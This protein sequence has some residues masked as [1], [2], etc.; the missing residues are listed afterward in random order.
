MELTGN[1]GQVPRVE[2]PLG[3]EAATSSAKV[4][5]SELKEYTFDR[6]KAMADKAAQRNA[7]YPV[8]PCNIY[9]SD[10]SICD[11]G[12][13]YDLLF[14]AV[15]EDLDIAKEFVDAVTGMDVPRDSIVVE[16]QRTFAQVRSEMIEGKSPMAKT[17]IDVIIRSKAGD[18]II[19]IQTY[20]QP[21]FA[22]RLRYYGASKD[23]SDSTKVGEEKYNLPNV[24]CVAFCSDVSM[25]SFLASE[26]CYHYCR[27]IN[28]FGEAI[29]D[30]R[31][32]I[33]I[34]FTRWDKLLSEGAPQAVADIAA[35]LAG[36]SSGTRYS[37]SIFDKANGLLTDTERSSIMGYVGTKFDDMRE[38]FLREG[39]QRGEQ[40][41]RQIERR[42]IAVD[43]AGF[44]ALLEQEEYSSLREV[45]HSIYDKLLDDKE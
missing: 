22:R 37:K 8:G 25:K 31:S 11:H 38:A 26:H 35:A 24:Y 10:G 15:M 36:Q 34:N 45:F 12:L 42:E 23:V 44:S 27:T 17:D 3:T 30:G 4:T 6:L 13:Q 14:G 1:K 32:T 16:P 18:F 39:E 41:G 5:D 21:L 29:D 33:L 9:Y 7:G 43:L 19:E 28:Q 2:T 40:R 20:A